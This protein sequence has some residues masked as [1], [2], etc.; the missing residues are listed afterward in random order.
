MT[1]LFASLAIVLSG[2]H[3]P[4][5]PFKAFPFQHMANA[6]AGVVIGPWY[7][8]LSALIAAIIRNALGTGTIFAFPGGIPGGIIVGLVYLWVR[9]D[10]AAWTEPIG[11]VFIGV[12]LSVLVFGPVMGRQVALYTFLIAFTLSSVAGAGIGY[13]ILKTLRKAKVLHHELMGI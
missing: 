7:A 5:G 12:G 8:A 2:V 13:F 1:A 6:V 9:R 11:T 3:I 10:W 4:V